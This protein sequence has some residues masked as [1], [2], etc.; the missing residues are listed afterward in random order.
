[1]TTDD[2]SDVFGSTGTDT[3]STTCRGCGRTIEREVPEIESHA[4]TWI[5]CKDE[6]CRTINRVKGEDLNA[7]KEGAEG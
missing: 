4:D 7:D 5:R 2:L 3:A 6:D 1:M